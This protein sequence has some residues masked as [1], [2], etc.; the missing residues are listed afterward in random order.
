[1]KPMPTNL[2]AVGTA[3]MQILRMAFDAK[4]EFGLWTVLRLGDGRGMIAAHFD[5]KAKKQPTTCSPIVATRDVS[6]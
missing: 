6:G 5:D 4:T 2:E 1:M 3:K